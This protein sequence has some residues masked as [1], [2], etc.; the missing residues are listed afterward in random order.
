MVIKKTARWRV[1][2]VAAAAAV[3][4]PMVGSATRAVA[5][6][7]SHAGPATATPIKHLVVIFNENVSFDHYFATYPK[8]ANTD[9]QRFVAQPGTPTVNGLSAELLTN[10][11]NLSNPQRLDPAQAVTCDQDHG[12]TA[13]QAAFDHGLMDAFVQHT[14]HG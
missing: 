1:L 14:G 12:Y 7:A 8:A 10:N 5:D 6:Q 4:A 2:T 3:V 13:E 9:G 11:P